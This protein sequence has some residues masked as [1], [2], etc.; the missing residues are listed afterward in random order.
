MNKRDRSI[1]AIEESH[2][3]GRLWWWFACNCVQHRLLARTRLLAQWW[4]IRF[5]AVQ[6]VGNVCLVDDDA[7]NCG[8]SWGQLATL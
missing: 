7:G 1:R 4:L 3:G 8:H 2:F 5:G 6:Y